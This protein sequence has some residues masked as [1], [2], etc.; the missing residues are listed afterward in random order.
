MDTASIDIE[1]LGDELFDA[2]RERRTINVVVE[3]NALTRKPTKEEVFSRAFLPARADR[4]S[5]L[6]I[7]AGK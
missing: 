4:P 7:A 1:A 5:K 6:T 2:L 3:A